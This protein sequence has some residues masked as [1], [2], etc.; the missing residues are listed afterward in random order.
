M[1]KEKIIEELQT[2]VKAP[3]ITDQKVMSSFTIDWRGHFKGRALAVIFPSKTIEVSNILKFA[4]KFKIVI[5]P[6]GGN[7]GLCGGATPDSSGHSIV[8]SL[9]KLKDIRSIDT[10]GNTI[11]VEAGCI[12]QDIHNEVE[13]KGRTFPINLSAKGS[14]T[15]GG[16]LATNAGGNNVLKY[17]ST[18]DLVLGIEAVLPDGKI[19][20]SLT[21]LHKDNTG[22]PIHKLLV[23]SEGTLGIITAATIKLFNLPK[24][25]STVFVEVESVEKS[26]KLLHYLQESTGEGVEAFEIMTKPILD[27]IHRQ[28]PNLEKPFKK[29]PNLSVLIE[30]ITTSEFDLKLNSKGETFFENRVFEIMS[31]IF[32]SGLIK[33]AIIAQSDLQ[34]KNLWEI[35]ENANIAQSKEGFQIKLDVSLPLRKISEFWVKT[36]NKLKEEYPQIIICAFGH[37]GD[38]NIHFNLMGQYVDDKIFYEKRFQLENIVYESVSHYGG[39][40]SAEH[41]IGQLKTKELEKY[42]DQNVIKLMKSIKLSIDPNNILNLGK[43]FNNLDN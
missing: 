14:C 4:N 36:E 7:T 10:V 40:F 43:I 6:Q 37:L 33:N 2:L 18:R 27:I 3:L 22:Y 24:A 38:G 20:N 1:K 25:R 9:I 8:M 12:L 30:F 26:L 15:I 42:K 23:G 28:F 34:R 21:A 5:V 29:I 13:E 31:T 32:N 35:R 16:N 17:G 41:G 19:I 39:S 11:N